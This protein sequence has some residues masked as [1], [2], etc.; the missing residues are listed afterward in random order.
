[1]LTLVGL[2]HNSASIELREKMAFQDGVLS[3]ALSRLVALDGIDEAMILSTCNRVE[4][5]VRAD[6][7]R[8]GLR[9]IREFLESD[10]AVTPGELERYTYHFADRDA[11][12][13]LFRVASGLDSMV[14][15]EPQI[16]GQVKQAYAAAREAGT[17]GTILDHLL[18]QTISAA[19]RVRTETG[20]SRHA[21]SIAFA[22]VEL[23]RKIFGD[24]RGRSA[25]L[26]GAGKMGALVATHLGSNGVDSMI[27]SSR[28]YNRSAL[29]AERIGGSACNWDES[30]DQLGK[31]DIV[32]TGTA[33]PGVILGRDAVQ[34]AIRRRRSRPLFIIDIAVPRD[35]DPNVNTLDNVYLY[36]VDDL[37]GVVDTNLQ[38]RKRAAEAAV[39]MIEDEVVSFD[40][41]VESL[42]ISPTIVALRESLL[43][44][45]DQE[46]EKFRSR[47]ELGGTDQEAQVRAMLRGVLHKVLH[48][49]T[50]HLKG[51]AERGDAAQTAAL[52]RRIFGIPAT[53]GDR[54]PGAGRRDADADDERPPGPSHIVKGGRE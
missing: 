53:T 50:L 52:Y 9:R 21:V 18:R 25:L 44:V 35:V 1:M 47:M 40:R 11:A 54:G 23:A 17:I 43:E 42:K 37:Q 14:L 12:R 28:T 45:G 34:H 10:R 16:L 39:S 31:V 32:V 48:R 30:F 22:A 7:T 27:V 38:E 4:I 33:A 51:S 36:D 26:L 19:K 13:H 20:I 3:D 2:N 29:L 15:G 5:V 46:F 6:D 24:L 8:V 41:W 49:P